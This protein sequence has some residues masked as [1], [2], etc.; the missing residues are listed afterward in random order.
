MYNFRKII[1]FITLFVLLFIYHSLSKELDSLNLQFEE[2]TTNFESIPYF[3]LGGGYIG[4][5]SF[6][7][8]DEINKLHKAFDIGNVSS[9]LF[10]S[11]AEG[12]TAI[13]FIKNFRIGFSG[14]SGSKKN[15]TTKDTFTIGSQTKFQFT[16]FRFDYGIV[17]MKSLALLLGAKLGWSTLTL[18]FYKSTKNLE[19]NQIINSAN[20]PN[21]HFLRINGNFWFIEPSFN[22]EFAATTFLMVRGGI[23][24]TFTLSPEWKCNEISSLNNVPSKLKADGFQ[25]VLGLFIGLFNY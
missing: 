8:F 12:F 5:F 15:E 24:Y 17:P 7:N 4:T 22:I 10:L 13:P 21:Y 2:A 1:L 23:A 16:G 19:W 6:C 18:E 9:P 3:G 20:D 14:I 11:G 25:I